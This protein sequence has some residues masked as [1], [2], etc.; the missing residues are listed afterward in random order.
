MPRRYVAR[1]HPA[2]PKAPMRGIRLS[3]DFPNVEAMLQFR[4]RI[5]KDPEMAYHM[6]GFKAKQSKLHVYKL[7][8]F[9]IEEMPIGNHYL[10]SPKTDEL[11]T[12]LTRE[13]VKLQTT[14]Y[15]QR[16]RD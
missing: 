7:D 14:N 12:E 16:K 5:N 10:L 9:D 11:K 6:E 8:F 4:D 2:M 15:E 13:I 3:L 1:N